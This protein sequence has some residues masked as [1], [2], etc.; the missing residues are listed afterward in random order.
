[1]KIGF[2]D[3]GIGGTTVLNESLNMLPKE[4]Y[5]YYSD[6]LHVPYGP[7]T[8]EE[9]KK[10]I[11]DAVSFLVDHKIKALVVAC[12]T[13]TSI[14]VNDLRQKYDFPIIGMEPAVKP[15]VVK[16]NGSGKRV[17]VFATALTL[18]ESKFQ[19]LVSE[20]DR[21]N[22]V[23]YLALPE[24]VNF[25]ENLEFDDQKVTLCLRGKLSSFKL[26]QYGTVVLGCTH[27]P[28]FKQCIKNIFPDGVNII[29]GSYGTIKHL[30][31]VL[32]ERGLLENTGSGSVEF[33]TSGDS[34]REKYKFEKVM[35][36]VKYLNNI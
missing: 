14:A 8:K 1:M 28:I 20:V 23:D 7:K 12:N 13:A 22:I 3:S 4:D 16:T 33:Y 21:N 10:Y 34:E 36:R 31:Q 24:L 26:Q 27:F 11:F 30:K 25:A 2:F 18:K 35:E 6:A 19:H 9:V 32:Q 17:L 5:I 15:A 29:D